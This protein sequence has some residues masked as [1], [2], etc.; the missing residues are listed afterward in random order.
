M[1]SLSSRLFNARH[2]SFLRKFRISEFSVQSIASRKK[3][4]I[5]LEGEVWIEVERNLILDDENDEIF[6]TILQSKLGPFEFIEY[7]QDLDIYTTDKVAK[8]NNFTI[9]AKI[10]LANSLYILHHIYIYV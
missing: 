4:D 7:N 6:R 9:F 10:F 2:K 8:I 3:N 1:K 5:L